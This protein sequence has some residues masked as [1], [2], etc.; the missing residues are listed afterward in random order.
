MEKSAFG[1]LFYWT[2]DASAT[3]DAEMKSSFVADDLRS[4]I[5]R[6]YRHTYEAN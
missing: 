3:G 6:I 2:R 4:L 5:P 1:G